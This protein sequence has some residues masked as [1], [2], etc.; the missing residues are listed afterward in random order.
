MIHSMVF[1]DIVTIVK[2]EI[3]RCCTIIPRRLES[4]NQGWK[5]KYFNGNVQSCH[6]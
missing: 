5:S 3:K 6:Q 2:R 4:K 1:N